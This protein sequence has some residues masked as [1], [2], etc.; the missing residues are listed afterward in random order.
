[1]TTKITILGAGAWGTAF[2][3][4]LAHNGHRVTLWCYEQDVADAINQDHENKKYLP[5]IKLPENISATSSM[6]EALHN[7]AL[8]FE[9]VPVMY[10][11]QIFQQAK[12]HVLPS[13]RWVLLSKG[14]EQ[15]TLMLPAQILDD[16]FGIAVT[17]AVIGGPNF[18][19][20]LSRKALTA[21]TIASADSALVSQLETLLANNYFITKRS[22]DLIAVHVGGAIKNVL[23]LATGIARGAGYKE[24]TIAYLLTEGLAEIATLAQHL[25]GKRETI[26]GLCG[27]GDMIVTCTGTL[28]KNLHV[29]TLLGEGKSLEQIKGLV[30]VMPEGINTTASLHELMKREGLHLPICKKTY[31]YIFQGI[32]FTLIPA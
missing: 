12:N 31:D 25:G 29:G 11:R 20:D 32:P 10:M 19:K 16:V 28:S 26:Y 21:T 7:A 30:P 18:A 13:A 24:N 3:T 15:H 8:I 6:H 27:L 9:A 22:S 2:A 5:D 17:K 1:M 4:L 14:I 23:A